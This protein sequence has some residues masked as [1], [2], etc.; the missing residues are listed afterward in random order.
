MARFRVIPS[1]ERFPKKQ[2]RAGRIM[3]MQLPEIIYIVYIG[4]ALGMSIANHA[5]EQGGWSMLIMC[6]LLTALLWWGG[7]FS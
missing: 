1:H 6:I 5:K 2:I 3:N 7:F 4:L